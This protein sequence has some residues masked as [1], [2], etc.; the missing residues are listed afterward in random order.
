LCNLLPNL[1]FPWPISTNRREKHIEREDK[2]EKKE[3]GGSTLPDGKCK[4]KKKMRGR[5]K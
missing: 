4:T 2:G 1:I 5:N 3:N